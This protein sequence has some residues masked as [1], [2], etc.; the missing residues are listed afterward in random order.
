MKEPIDDQLVRRRRTTDRRP[1]WGGVVTSIALHVGFGLA[2]FFGPALLASRSEPLEF[3]AVQ[4]VPVQALGVR[5]PPPAPPQP[6]SEPPPAPVEPTPKPKPKKPEPEKVEEK[7]PEPNPVETEPTERPPSSSTS[8]TKA[9]ADRPP[10]QRQGSPTGN[11]RGTAPIGAAVAGLDNPDFTYGYYLDQMLGLIAANWRPP[12]TG[13]RL[14]ATVHFLIN[15]DGS[16]E[17][18]SL[19]Q[20]SGNSAF[21]LAGL[22][23][24]QSSSPLPP[25]PASYRHESLGVN[26][27]LR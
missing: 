19:A 11:P 12:V 1:G 3:V 6:K 10:V 23:A 4:I 7:K 17:E 18:I 9:S 25:L 8:P 5:R 15:R 22:R 26:L 20:P 2:L 13:E 27:I 16:I 21:D 14:Q 24:V